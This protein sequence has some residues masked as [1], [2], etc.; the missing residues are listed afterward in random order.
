[1][2]VFVSVSLII[3]VLD[4]QGNPLLGPNVNERS[5]TRDYLRAH[6]LVKRTHVLDP[7]RMRTHG[8]RFTDNTAGFALNMVNLVH[9]YSVLTELLDEQW[10]SSVAPCVR[11]EP[12]QLQ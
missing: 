1:M 9:L 8:E 11:F 2:R 3:K 6:C 12:I 7:E 4:L 5:R 10:P